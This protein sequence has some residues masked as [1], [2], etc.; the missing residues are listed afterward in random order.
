VFDGNWLRDLPGRHDVWA[1]GETVDPFC[2]VDRIDQGGLYVGQPVRAGCHGASWTQ[3]SF[4]LDGIDLTDP[5]RGGAPMLMPPRL[6]LESVT[7]ERDRLPASLS[8]G[9]AELRLETRRPGG[10]WSGTLE[11]HAASGRLQGEAGPTPPSAWYGSQRDVAALIQGDVVPERTSLLLAAADSRTERFEPRDP[12]AL[13]G[14]DRTLFA[15]LTTKATPHDELG[16][17]GALQ[18]LGRPLAGRA[19][20][21]DRRLEEHERAGHAQASWHRARAGLGIAAAYSR[22]TLH[23]DVARP[24]DGVVERLLDGPVPELTPAR[25][26]RERW[27]LAA[28]W[29]RSA[30][31][32]GQAPHSIHLDARVESVSLAARPAA[33][34]GLVGESVDGVPARVWEYAWAGPE[35]RRQA[36]EF[37]L[38]ATDRVAPTRWLEIAAGVRFEAV[39]AS[40]DGGN[41]IRWRTLSPRLSTRLRLGGAT[42]LHALA[43]YARYRHRLPL[44]ALAFGDPAA[45][46]GSSFLW[47]DANGDGRAQEAERG[48][49]VARHGPGGSFA[50]IDA[51]LRP[52]RTD[53]LVLGLESSPADGVVL[54][55]LALH[56]EERD[57]LESVN[58]G[59]PVASYRVV[60][61]PDP[62]VDFVG[63]SD[64]R[65]LPLY[66]RDPVSFGL[67]RYRL[68]NPPGHT[69]LHEGFEL[70]AE[71]ARGSLRLLLGAA[72]YRSEG[73]SGWRGFRSSENDQGLIGELFDDPNADSYGRGR[74]FFDR[75]YV[76]K[77][78]A[79]YRAPADVRIGTAVRYQ[80]GQPFARFV[81]APGLRQGPDFVHAVPDGRHRFAYTLTLDARVEKGFRIG[82]G[83][84][85]AVVEVWNALGSRQG[86]EESVI[87]APAFRDRIALYT[88]P[89]R[90]FR[91]GLRLDLP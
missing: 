2:I 38:A 73:R 55:F 14:R 56:R 62:Y 70:W 4:E 48:P 3:T 16:L 11:G 24:P 6:A 79:S 63:P 23:P 72:A 83:R 80:D 65:L 25:R 61:I 49:L 69:M 82:A 58:V 47:Q 41:E 43:S 32:W 12:A 10:A 35:S 45:A 7:L 5:E 53:E 44:A 51:D 54:R 20:Y 18:A 52:P 15:R 33:P 59:V 17:R 89:P 84:A 60:E 74:L 29:Q 57:L 28:R 19:L 21:A 81:V 13:P 1:L 88:Q 34:A 78:A 68:T 87:T 9:G 37:A 90:V 26:T 91:L 85:A 86:V 66:D 71:R 36:H 30:G 64:D 76:V 75:N 31:W 42:R 22:A 50:A 46:T 67:D 27:S 40:A 8:G 77:L 39:A